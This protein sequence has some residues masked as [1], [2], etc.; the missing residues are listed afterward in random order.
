MNRCTFVGKIVSDFE[1]GQRGDVNYLRFRLAVRRPYGG[2]D[3][4][5]PPPMDFI[6]CVAFRSTADFI[7][8][9]FK[10]NDFIWVSAAYH[11]DQYQDQD[12]NTRYSHSFVIDEAGFCTPAPGSNNSGGEEKVSAQAAAPTPTPEGAPVPLPF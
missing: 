9:Y 3:K 5:G 11:S 2:K 12:G 10:R 7:G 8:K 6:P 1:T 4:E